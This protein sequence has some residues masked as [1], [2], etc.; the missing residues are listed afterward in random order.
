MIN[1][2]RIKGFFHKYHYIILESKTSLL[3]NFL[4]IKISSF[5]KILS[6]QVFDF[7]LFGKKEYCF[8]YL[9]RGQ[10]YSPIK[11]ALIS[12]FLVIE[13]NIMGFMKI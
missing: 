6:S 11:L 2:N 3:R 9:D 7:K 10:T 5:F 4:N 1:I 12:V 13:L 8:F